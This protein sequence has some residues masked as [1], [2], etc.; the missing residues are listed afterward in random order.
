MNLECCADR[1][2]L[3]VHCSQLQEGTRDCCPLPLQM[4]SLVSRAEGLRMKLE[5][6]Q[7]ELKATQR[8]LIAEVRE[9]S[10]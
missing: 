5:R 8:A 10:S 6:T 2:P 7:A 9:L 3:F 4:K 1:V